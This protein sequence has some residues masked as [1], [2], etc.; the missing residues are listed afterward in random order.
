MLLRSLAVTTF[1]CVLGFSSVA[2]AQDANTPPPPSNLGGAG[3]SCR[4][5]ADC[6]NGLKC[7]NQLC[8]DEREGQTCG[9]TSD[10][11]GEL[12]CIGGKCTT[13]IGASHYGG[14]GGGPGSEEWMSFKFDDGQPHPF[15]GVTIAGGFDTLGVTG[16]GAGLFNTGT[17]DGAF[18]FALNGGVFIGNHQLTFEVAPYTF[19]FDGKANGPVFEMNGSYAYFIP[20]ATQGTLHLYYPLRFGLG[21]MAGGSNSLNLAFFQIR[22]DLIGAAIQIG[23]VIIDLHLPSFRYDLTD[24]SGT[25]L[26]IFDWVFGTSIG[27]VF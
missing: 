18:L 12:R 21:M 1:V 11:G 14:G 23:H 7:V 8:T 10:C 17:I 19:I 6:K 20:L 3:E 9:A 16:N 5:R 4:A 13:P 25:Q 2:F 27:Y 26:H 24:K 22:A 15:I